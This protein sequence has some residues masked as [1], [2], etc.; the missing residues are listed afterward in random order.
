MSRVK[1]WVTL[2]LAFALCLLGDVVDPF[3]DGGGEHE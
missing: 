1:A 2:L 3:V